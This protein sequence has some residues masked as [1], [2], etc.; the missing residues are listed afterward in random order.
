MV[1]L[2]VDRITLESNGSFRLQPL[3]FIQEAGLKIAI[4]GETGS[5]KTTVL[6]IIAGLAQPSAG[7]VKLRGELV[8]GPAQKLVPG[9][10][11]I[12]YLSQYFELPKS[13]RV[14]QVLSYASNI[15][16]MAADRIHRICE[17]GHLMDRRTDQLSGGERQRIA[18]ARL[19][20]TAPE[21]LL[22]D[23]PF[24]NLDAMHRL[25]MKSV[26]ERIGDQ[27]GITSILVSHDA[28][29]T[30]PWADHLMVMHEGTVIQQGHPEVIYRRPVSEYAGALFGRYN[31]FPVDP[32]LPD[33]LAFLRPDDL[34]ITD[35]PDADFSG[36]VVR[37][38]FHGPYYEVQID[39][40]DRILTTFE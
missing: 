27:L 5:G 38:N 21:L 37:L 30:L 40:G 29:D 8:P 10:P 13:L 39:T 24:S 3:S 25:Q 12:A 4:A 2:E 6:R 33:K 28:S 1:L 19:L 26:I 35:S 31:L 11:S 15:S 7:S 22:L 18:L 17:I 32:A 20:V 9:H 34:V 14:G 16:D 36:K 23:E